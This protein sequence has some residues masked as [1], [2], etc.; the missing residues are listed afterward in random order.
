MA[1]LKALLSETINNIPSQF[2]DFDTQYWGHVDKL[3]DQIVVLRAQGIS[4]RKLINTLS[5]LRDEFDDIDALAPDIIL[6]VLS[7]LEGF[8]SPHMKID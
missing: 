6:E 2:D 7:F 3:R 4:K 1:N 5:K 8:C